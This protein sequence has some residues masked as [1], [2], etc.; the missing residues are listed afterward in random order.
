M[1]HGSTRQHLVMHGSIR[2]YLVMHGSAWQHKAVLGDAWRCI[3]C[4]VAQNEAWW[5]MVGWAGR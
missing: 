1:V 3:A 5:H 2:K 4:S